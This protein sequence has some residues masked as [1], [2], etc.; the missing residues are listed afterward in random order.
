MSSTSFKGYLLRQSG[1]LKNWKRQYYELAGHS[2]RE[3]SDKGSPELCRIELVKPCRILTVNDIHKPYCFKIQLKIKSFLFAAETTDDFVKWTN[4]LTDAIPDSEKQTQD[5]DAKKVNVNDFEIIKVIG[6]GTYGK[7]SLV[8]FMGDGKLYAMKSMSKRKLSEENNI[9]NVLVEKEILMKSKNPFL[10]H[11]YFCFQT[12]AKIFLI[13]DYVPGGELFHRLKEEGRFSEKRTQLYAAEILLGI[14]H[15][16]KKGFIYR[17]IKPENILV[18]I[19]GHLKITD[20]GFAKGNMKSS[21]N[22][23]SSFCGTPEYLAPEVFKQQPYNRSVD[24]WSLGALIYEMLTGSPPFYDQNS[25]KMYMAILFNPLDFP[26]FLSNDAIDLLRKLLEKDPKKRLGSGPIGANEIKVHP[27]F[28]EIDWDKVLRK[29]IRPSWIPP[30]E[31]PTDTSHFDPQFTAET[32]GV[33]FEDPNLVPIDAQNAFVNF[34]C[35]NNDESVI[36]ML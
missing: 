34:T 20:F 32:P 15:L 5:T 12:E 13:L 25:K 10:V 19:D 36:D 4:L 1:I 2:L 31:N 14:D 16:H 21:S 7:V 27:F 9:E 33:S 11:A 29:D 8:R 18:D 23:T 24:W 6:R 30:V 22:T 17:D 26:K 35:N 28:C 3:F